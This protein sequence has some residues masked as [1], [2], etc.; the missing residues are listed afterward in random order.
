MIKGQ[1]N[2]GQFG[3]TILAGK[4][5]PQEHIKPG[6]AGVRLCGIYSF[7]AI[8][9]GRG[10]VSEGELTISS[11]S[12]IIVTRSRNT[13]LMLSCQDHKDKG[14]IAERPKIGVQNKSRWMHACV[15]LKATLLFTYPH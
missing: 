7:K 4:F 8:T 5:I 6:K 1:L 9:D 10:I 14:K 11:Y 15:H 2:S 13:A 3:I 12:E